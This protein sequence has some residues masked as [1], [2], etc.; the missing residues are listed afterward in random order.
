VLYV[1]LARCCCSA[2]KQY[3][4]TQG[5]GDRQPD[6]CPPH[7]HA[8]TA[9]MVVHYTPMACIASFSPANRRSCVAMPR[10]SPVAAVGAPATA[11]HPIGAVLWGHARMAHGGPWTAMLS[12]GHRSG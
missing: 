4:D 5:A 3:P 10:E 9:A 7:Y 12:Q 11:A 8:P 6:D 2:V 1:F